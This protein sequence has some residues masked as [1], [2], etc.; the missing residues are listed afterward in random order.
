[1]FMIGLPEALVILALVML[2]IF[3]PSKLPQLARAIGQSIKEIKKAT[4]EVEEEVVDEKL[5]KIAR[6][7]GIETEGK[8]RE[9]IIGEVMEK[10]GKSKSKK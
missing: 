9:E 2:L 4:R 5:L 1:M 7:L 6:E 3:A 8:S 10:L